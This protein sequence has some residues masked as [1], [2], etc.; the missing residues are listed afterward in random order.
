MYAKHDIVRASV[1][2]GNLNISNMFCCI[3]GNLRNQKTPVYGH[4]DSRRSGIN[5]KLVI[6]V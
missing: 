1:L 3:P 6:I 4:R 5:A 2:L